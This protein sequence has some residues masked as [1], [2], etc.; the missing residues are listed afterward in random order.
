[1]GDFRRLIVEQVNVD[2]GRFFRRHLRQFV[3]QR[4]ANINHVN[5]GDKRHPHGDRLATVGVVN[6]GGRFAQPARERG[7]IAQPRRRSR[8]V[9]AD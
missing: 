6:A 8:T 5:P 7:N 4:T 2:P 9:R 1:M 3:L